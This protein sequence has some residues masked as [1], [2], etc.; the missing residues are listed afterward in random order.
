MAKRGPKPK[1]KKVEQTSS[2]ETSE[3]MTEDT[4]LDFDTG[5]REALYDKYGK[6]NEGLSE[7]STEEEVAEETEESPEEETETPAEKEEAVTEEPSETEEAKDEKTV[8][9]GA[10]HEEREKR[11]ALGLELEE[12][13]GQL[14]TVLQDIRQLSDQKK[15]EETAA[16]EELGSVEVL[17]KRIMALEGGQR[18]TARDMQ[19]EKQAKQDQALNSDIKKVDAELEEEGFPAFEF[20]TAKVTD[21]LNRLIKE[22]PQNKKT[23]DNPEGW[24]KVYKEVVFPTI[25]SKFAKKDKADLFEK[26]KD[27]K[28]EA[29]LGGP[30][31]KPEEA[32][33]EEWTY[34]DYLRMR[35]NK[36]YS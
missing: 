24:K 5:D 16:E 8:P 10:L 25:Y 35:F 27:L 29:N 26:K 21:E 36:Q 4:S 13:K 32:K 31:K 18:K 28:L 17:E 12:V 15:T 3:G 1:E 14:H 23:L 33:E 22:D 30:G 11:K 7:T 34:N 19:T 2:Q 20:M 9:L 6:E